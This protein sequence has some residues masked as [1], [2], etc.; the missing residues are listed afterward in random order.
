MFWNSCWKVAQEMQL[1]AVHHSALASRSSPAYFLFTRTLFV[2]SLGEVQL[3]PFVH[4]TCV[5]FFEHVMSSAMVMLLQTDRVME[6]VIKVDILGVFW[7]LVGGMNGETAK[8]F[9]Y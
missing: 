8:D 7:F 3:C 9:T 1:H 2:Q 5:I 6:D 4:L